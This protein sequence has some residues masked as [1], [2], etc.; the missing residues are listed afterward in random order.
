M[1]R[2]GEV[3]VYDGKGVRIVSGGMPVLQLAHAAMRESHRVII[4][5]KGGDIAVEGRRR[6]LRSMLVIAMPQRIDDDFERGKVLTA[7][8][9]VQEITVEEGRPV[10]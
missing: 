2:V 3:A 8:G 6:L 1:L 10:V 5:S 7:T 9:I 4:C